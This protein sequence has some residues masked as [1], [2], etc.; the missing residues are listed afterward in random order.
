MLTPS[1]LQTRL[2]YNPVTGELFW[3]EKLGTDRWTRA[4]NTM[5][6]GKAALTADDGRGYCYGHVDGEKITAHKAAWA[7][8][9]G[10][11]PTKGLDHEDGNRKHNAIKNLSDVGH[12]GNNKN[13]AAQK[14]KSGLPAGVVHVKSRKILPYSARIS[15]KGKQ[16]NIGNFA[17]P[18]DAHQAYLN[19][20]LQHGYSKRHGR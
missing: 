10:S 12:K 7:I 9:Y 4:W 2:D 3:K 14:N 1:Y 13:K 17:N 15:I 6:V 18:A 8:Y 5:W 20:A 11:F 19:A 16:T